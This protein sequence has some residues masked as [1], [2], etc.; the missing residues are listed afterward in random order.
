MSHE[1]PQDRCQ[2]HEAELVT[3]CRR[4][5]REQL[6]DAGQLLVADGRLVDDNVAI[7]I[8]TDRGPAAADKDMNQDFILA[9]RPFRSCGPRRV[10]SIM[11]VADGV[12]AALYAEWAAETACWISAHA[13]LTNR[14]QIDAADLAR[15]AFDSA[16]RAVGRLAEE[17]AANPAFFKPQDE[18]DATWAYRLR[19]RRIAQTTLLLAWIDCEGLHVAS[20][21]DAGAVCRVMQGTDIK[22]VGQ[23]VAHCDLETSLVNAIGP[24]QTTIRQFDGW[25]ETAIESQ[26]LFAAYTD[27]IARGLRAD[28]LAI[29]DRPEMSSENG[30]EHPARSYTRRAIDERPNEHDDNLTLGVLLYKA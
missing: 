23:V 16:G 6:V 22:P 17:I 1:S 4:E 26:M 28:P 24:H 30:V 21:G 18:F 15:F 2:P 12:S 3:Q 29:L 14:D 19:K 8:Y 5:C 25:F 27:G 20:I 11:A 7:S 9:W 13:L 10:Q